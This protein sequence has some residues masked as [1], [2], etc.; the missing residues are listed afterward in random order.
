MPLA[1]QPGIATDRFA[2]EI[3]CILKARCGA[4][5]AAE[6]QTVRHLWQR[7]WHSFLIE[8]WRIALPEHTLYQLRRAQARCAGVVRMPVVRC[9]RYAGVVRTPVVRY[10]RC[11]GVVRKPVVLEARYGGGA[12][13]GAWFQ[14]KAR[15]AVRARVLGVVQIQARCALRDRMLGVV[16]T[17]RFVV[18][19]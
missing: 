3:V 16:P 5:A 8:M 13:R 18:P 15:C 1:A 17:E 2:R 14:I 6:C 9:A 11:A 4:L 10:A 12:T 19:A 7:D